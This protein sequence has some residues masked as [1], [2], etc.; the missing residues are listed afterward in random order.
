[1]ASSGRVQKSIKNVCF[2][3]G[4]Q[5][6]TVALNFIARVKFVEVLGLAANGLNGLFLEVV[7]MLS[8]AELGVG[9]AITYS[10]YKPLAHRDE[11]KISQIM[12]LFKTAYLI[13]AAVI[14]VAGM[15][16]TPFIHLIV[17]DTDFELSYIRRIFVLFVLR[18]VS[19]YLMSYKTSLL[20]ADQ[21]N[22]VV[23]SVNA[24]T[25]TLCT[26]L[27]IVSLYIKG[28][29]EL[30]LIII[31][32]F[33]LISNI[34]I[35]LY[36][37]KNYPYV[38]RGDKLS[39]EECREILSN[40]KHIFISKL[41]GRITNSTDNILISVLVSTVATGIYSNY[42]LIIT[43][44]KQLFD[45]IMSAVTG[46]FG[47]LMVTESP[48]RCE[49]TMRNLVFMFFSFGVFLSGGLISA[50][51]PFIEFFFKKNALLDSL[52]LFVCAFNLY[53]S[54]WI[55]PLWHVMSVSGL[56]K[57][58]KKISI[59]GSTVNLIVSL[60]LGKFIGMAG[61]FIGTTCTYL[62]QITL[63]IILLYKKKFLMP[64]KSFML[65]TIKM[66]IIAFGVIMLE[67]YVCGFIE[68]ESLLVSFVLKGFA[69]AAMSITII[70][71]LYGRSNEMK[72]FW[73]LAMRRFKRTRS[74][75][76]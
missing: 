6:L 14:F 18:T 61:I 21:K 3:M 13:I 19:T 29:F 5:V 20:V 51:P 68:V 27:C 2:G 12:W 9:T 23:S 26:L 36:S 15:V 35:T 1:M 60:V 74:V 66:F 28:S 17:N 43:N 55:L 11:K 4:T 73:D 71:I 31:I 65:E 67:R 50:V 57:D 22:Y 10:L 64:Y 53:T 37:R 56:F 62:L 63:K 70:L 33:N 69:S 34:I 30:Y 49:K 46:S 7:A 38:K 44:V 72:Y 52:T 54:V 45:Q 59:A 32:I 39:K 42:S 76:K 48:Q 25:K 75:E 58:D 41:S 24:V 40:I 8:L 16:L 47:N